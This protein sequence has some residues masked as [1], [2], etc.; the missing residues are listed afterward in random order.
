MISNTNAIVLRT[1]PYGDT[2]L[3]VTA[4]TEVYGLQ[5]YLVKGARSTGKK[6]QSLRP[7][8]QPSALLE[9]VVYNHPTNQLQYI[10]EMK[11]ARVYRQVLGSV[12]H[13][14]VATYLVE[15]LSKCIK[16]AEPNP[17]LFEKSVEYFTL[18]DEAEAGV[19]ANLPLHFALYLAG[20]MGFRPENN[21]SEACPVFDLQAG[22]FTA[23]NDH[24]VNYL[25]GSA[26]KLTHDL[27]SIDHPVTLY[28]V[29]M[30]RAK[31]Q[32]LLTAFEQYFAIHVDGFGHM[33]SLEVLSALFGT[34]SNP[35]TP[36]RLP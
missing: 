18:I 35:S 24:A 16:Q 25:D 14:A 7:Y 36:P 22:R 2:S 6:G 3:V 4:L 23:G 5:S 27:L 13:F 34:P 32:Q 12:V 9:L 31:R 8:L 26:A 29:K 20:E 30:P 15:L 11:W 21:Y 1:V 28:R 10:R 33:R 17:E 19:V